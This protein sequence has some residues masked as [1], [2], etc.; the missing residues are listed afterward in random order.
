[1]GSRVK[2]CSLCVCVHICVCD[3]YQPIFSLKQSDVTINYFC[4]LHDNPKATI[5]S[6]SPKKPHKARYQNTKFKKITSPQR[7]TERKSERTK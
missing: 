1:M 6:R 3:H 4:L 5:Y 2:M 7:N